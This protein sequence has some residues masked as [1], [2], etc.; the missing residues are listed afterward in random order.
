[1]L[2]GDIKMNA[3]YKVTF[4]VDFKEEKE[5]GI[6]F[7]ENPGDIVNNIF[8]YYGKDEVE[9]VTISLFEDYDCSVLPKIIIEDYFSSPHNDV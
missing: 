5:E 7:G 8:K 6:A 4:Y 3:K 2:I 1:M 9:E